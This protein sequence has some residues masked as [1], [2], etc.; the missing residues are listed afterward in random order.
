[1]YNFLK[2]NFFYDRNIHNI[3]FFEQITLLKIK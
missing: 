1:M 3:I 2:L